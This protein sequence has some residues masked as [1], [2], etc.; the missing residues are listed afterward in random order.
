MATLSPGS[1]IGAF[2]YEVIKA[3]EEDP[4]AMSEVYLAK[5]RTPETG[6][7]SQVVIKI[8]L[9]QAAEHSDFYQHTLEN[10]VERLRRLKHPG[11]VRIFPI[12][13]A[14]LRNLP[15]MAQAT[16]LAGDPW[17]T[18]SEY[19][20]GGSLTA[21]LAQQQGEIGLALEITRSLAAT[22]DYLHSRKQ[23]HLDLKPA[24]VL[25][26]SPPTAGRPVEPVLIDFGIARDI[27]QRG[28]EARTLQYAAPERLP[29]NGGEAE[30]ES[31]ARPHPA[32]D[33]YALGVLLYELLTGRLPLQA[34]SQRNLTALI[35]QE[36]P[37]PPSTYNGRVNPE[38]DEL[39]LRLLAKEA[40]ERPTAEE[41]AVQ[42][43]AL[44]IRGGYLPRYPSS[45]Y[46]APQSPRTR[47][48]QQ[49][50]RAALLLFL[51]LLLL[52]QWLFILGSYR[53]WRTELDLTPNGW[54]RL[55]ENIRQIGS[56]L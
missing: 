13:R 20:P 38:L 24:N 40:R 9:G 16:G 7:E 22:L 8:G 2:P 46:L 12:Q 47:Q 45:A 30:P 29:R 23:V 14:G 34:R 41:T 5:V 49:G 17:F 48:P 31:L 10:E 37:K 19:L 43:E 27:G 39:V 55:W 15:Y 11:I 33:L 18:V 32:M 54:W 51:C 35:L 25:F 56:M 53:Y 42:L 6:E 44:A 3:L 50:S 4:G 52:L 26:R 1:R 36:A 21:L 28:L